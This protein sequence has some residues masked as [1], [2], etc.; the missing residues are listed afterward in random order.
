MDYQK[1]RT[2]SGNK[3]FFDNQS[4]SSIE[5]YKKTQFTN[6]DPY[7]PANTKKCMTE[8][9]LKSDDDI[10]IIKEIDIIESTIKFSKE[11][12]ISMNLTERIINHSNGI[13]NN[14]SH[15]DSS[16][17]KSIVYDPVCPPS[18]DHSKEITITDNSNFLGYTK[19]NILIFLIDIIFIL[20]LYYTIVRYNTHEQNNKRLNCQPLYRFKIIEE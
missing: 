18:H 15:L 14:S 9:L 20:I 3:N 5:K 13:V 1:S 17:S 10:S 11:F 12:D 6:N 19:K 4:S 7:M 8:F 2:T 16:N